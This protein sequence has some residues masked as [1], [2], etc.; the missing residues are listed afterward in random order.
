MSCLK[1]ISLPLTFFYFLF[2]STLQAQSDSQEKRLA[3]VIGNSDYAEGYLKNPIN[4][5]LLISEALDSLGFDIIL[6]TNIRS[7]RDFIN[8]IREFGEKRNE[9]DVAFV[10][11]AGHGIQIGSENFLLPTEELFSNENDVIDYGVSVQNI[12]RYL[13]DVTDKVNILILDACRNNPFE[14]KWDAKRSIEQGK[15][16]AKIPPPTGSLI[17]FSTEAGTT[18]EDGLGSNSVYCLSLYENM[19]RPDISLDQVFRNVRSEVLRTT[20]GEQRPIE[21]SQLTGDTYYL[22]PKSSIEIRTEVI[23]LMINENLSQA[24]DLVDSYLLFHENNYEFLT[25]K[26]HIMLLLSKDSLAYDY[27]SQALDLKTDYR[28]AINHS[29]IYAQTDKDLGILNCIYKPELDTAFDYYANQYSNDFEILL[30]QARNNIFS[31]EKT[32]CQ[33]GLTQL[34]DLS[35]KLERNQLDTN[36]HQFGNWTGK[37]KVKWILDN[38]MMYAHECMGNWDEMIYW[39]QKCI[40]SHRE[41]DPWPHI[42]LS[43]AYDSKLYELNRYELDTGGLF[44]KS[45]FHLN[46]AIGMTQDE[47][48]NN[49]LKIEYLDVIERYSDTELTISDSLV[50]FSIGLGQSALMQINEN[51]SSPNMRKSDIQYTLAYLEFLRGNYFKSISYS[52]LGLVNAESTEYPLQQFKFYELNCLIYQ[53][54]DESSLFCENMHKIQGFLQEYDED[55]I[56]GTWS[57]YSKDTFKPLMNNCNEANN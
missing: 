42:S 35:V 2:A 9:Y 57:T 19:L 6:D 11:Y 22:N 3:L 4:D 15:G 45:L 32:R 38:N 25:L 43:R 37:H 14:R 55:E 27:Y 33:L 49:Y 17:A 44:S 23:D 7:R 56:W 51:F 18:A 1:K 13:N 36:Y 39:A 31:R 40:A 10:Y 52:A 34:E 53:M 46:L 8:V 54:V 47:Y 30:Q 28:E 41:D 48:L 16:L 12:L 5:A 24:N 21:A 50:E 29:I 26:G 20:S